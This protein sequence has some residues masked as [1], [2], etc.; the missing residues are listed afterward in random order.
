MPVLTYYWSLLATIQSVRESMKFEVQST[1]P[2]AV[3]IMCG[4]QSQNFD[5]PS[6]VALC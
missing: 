3:L 2:G 4:G 1:L 5:G 6:L